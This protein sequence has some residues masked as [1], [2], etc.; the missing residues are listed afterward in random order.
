M[1]QLL[2]ILTA[3]FGKPVNLDLT[4]PIHLEILSALGE[5][6]IVVDEAERERATRLASAPDPAPLPR[7]LHRVRNDLV[8]IG[9]AVP[10][11][12]PDPL[13]ARLQAMFS[14]ASAELIKL[15]QGGAVA[16]RKRKPAP[17]RDAL[18]AAFDHFNIA[19]R[20]YCVIN[21]SYGFST[22]GGPALGGKDMGKIMADL[23]PKIKGKADGG[24]V[25]KIVKELLGI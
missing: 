18:E 2:A 22:R 16:L 13:G 4:Q 10:E 8:M 17:P 12:L 19:L 25:S 9:R 21:V 20:I 1:A 14:E 6:E 7:T 24:E 15:F 23:N 11:P 5:L 3:S